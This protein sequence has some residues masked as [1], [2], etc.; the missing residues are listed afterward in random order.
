[1]NIFASHPDALKCAQYLDDKRV[2]KMVLETAQMLSTA[3]QLDSDYDY[4]DLVYKPTYAN[5][6]CNVWVRQSKH[7]KGRLS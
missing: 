1:M 3:I 7:Y 2:V 6:P 4:K 5:H